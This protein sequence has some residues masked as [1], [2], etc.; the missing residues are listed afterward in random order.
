MTT[1]ATVYLYCIDDAVA[2]LADAQLQELRAR[3]LVLY[4]CAYAAQRRGLPINDL[5]VFAGLGVLGDILAGT[6]EFLSFNGEAA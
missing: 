6:S 5:A 2:G 1:G 4:A 3:G